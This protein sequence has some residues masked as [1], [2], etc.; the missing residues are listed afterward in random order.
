M[1][2]WV[3]LFSRVQWNETKQMKTKPRTRDKLFDRLL[4]QDLRYY[5]PYVF[6]YWP[7]W[8]L[9][10]I[11]FEFGLWPQSVTNFDCKDKLLGWL[12]TFEPFNLPYGPQL[13]WLN[14]MTTLYVTTGPLYMLL[15]DHTVCHYMATLYATIWPHHTVR[16]YLTTPN[17]SH[18]G[19]TFQLDRFLSCRAINI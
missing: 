7:L 1:K 11:R 5:I 12:N 18:T 3:T 19:E 14:Y 9:W 10:W 15:Y 17:A 6:A 8:L 16:H 4:Q 13:P 2:S